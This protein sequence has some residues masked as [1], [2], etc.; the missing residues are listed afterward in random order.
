M[1]SPEPAQARATAA[2]AVQ[3]APSTTP[4]ASTGAG[5]DLDGFLAVSTP[6]DAAPPSPRDAMMALR[7]ATFV[8]GTFGKPPQ[9]VDGPPAFMPALTMIAT[10][11]DPKTP[12]VKRRPMLDAGVAKLEPARKVETGE[13]AQTFVNELG[14]VHAQLEIDATL[15]VKSACGQAPSMFAALAKTGTTLQELLG[16]TN[17]A[18]DLGL[19]FEDAGEPAVLELAGQS[20]ELVT[21]DALGAFIELATATLGMIEGG[22]PENDREAPLETAA[23]VLAAAHG[24][25]DWAMKASLFVLE[26]IG[27]AQQM[28]AKAPDAGKELLAFTA[29]LRELPLG[30]GLDVI[31]GFVQLAQLASNV[32]IMLDSTKSVVD[33]VDAGVG[34][35][36]AVGGL[37]TIGGTVADLA[38]AVAVGE[39]LLAAGGAIGF[40]V[41]PIAFA[42]HTYLT[43]FP[44]LRNFA[45][46]VTADDVQHVMDF[47]RAIDDAGGRIATARELEQQDPN[48]PAYQT[49]A[50][51]AW[52]TVMQLVASPPQSKWFK[53][54]DREVAAAIAT[55]KLRSAKDPDQALAAARTLCAILADVLESVVPLLDEQLG[56]PDADR[57]ALQDGMMPDCDQPSE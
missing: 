6:G 26:A 17:S 34:I 50:Q 24:A 1:A 38:G 23:A 7:A 5:F 30:A 42:V 53:V 19:A 20:L 36:E 2:P 9:K 31:D 12:L 49:A 43:E 16:A 29:E 45:V 46:G 40:V 47:G 21:P 15:A 44:K 11:I 10:A 18:L 22:V 4:A 25:L 51:T 14:L 57:I 8:L 54:L 41:G 32:N 28:R 27:T 39:V 3:P 56:L 13:T 52:T 48:N 35:V 33:R 37:L 55:S